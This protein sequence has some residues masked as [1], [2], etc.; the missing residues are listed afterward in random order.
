MKLDLA[1]FREVAAF[2]QFG[3]DMDAATQQLLNRG[4]RLTELLKQV[5]YQPMD[6][7][8]QVFCIFAGVRGFLDRIDDKDVSEFELAF[9]NHV[10]SVHS[11]ILATITKEGALSEATEAKMKEITISYV[12]QFWIY[13]VNYRLKKNLFSTFFFSLIYFL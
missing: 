1:Q 7:A 12:D 2:A 8:N 3:S 11:D 5:Q 6:V 4:V 10:A 13:S 9:N